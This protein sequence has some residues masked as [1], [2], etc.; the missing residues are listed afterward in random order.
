MR[1][2]LM[3]LLVPVALLAA[4]QITVPSPDLSIFAD[5]GPG[6]DEGPPTDPGRDPG[7][8]SGT[9]EGGQD[10]TPPGDPGVPDD[11]PVD[12][13]PVDTGWDPGPVDTGT[14][15]NETPMPGNYPCQTNQG[16]LSGECANQVCTCRDATECDG[17]L[18]CDA[19]ETKWTGT[20]RCLAPRPLYAGCKQ[21]AHC[22]SAACDQQL[23]YCAKCADGGATCDGTFAC[24]GGGCVQGCLGC[25][26]APPPAPVYTF[27][28]SG[29]F[30]AAVQ[31]CGPNG[32]EYK[33]GLN[34]DCQ[35][36]DSWCKSGY[37]KVSDDGASSFCGCRVDQDCGGGVC[38]GGFCAIP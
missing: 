16:C 32:G 20:G 37:C 7:T 12:I 35:F 21:H 33:R 19:G 31:F 2:T 26:V 34:E 4:C 23:F 1:K 5:S 15:L 18:W 29:C 11:Q 17:G 24:C 25:A 3:A 38:L 13:G 30:D 36:N 14:D 22:E 8:E 27:C 6:G 9:D 28:M 10:H